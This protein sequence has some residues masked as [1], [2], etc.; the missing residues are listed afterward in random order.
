MILL[1]DPTDHFVEMVNPLTVRETTKAYL[2]GLFLEL[3]KVQ[4]FRQDSIVLAYAGAC[5]T[6]RFEK[7]QELGDW[8][9]WTM[10]FFPK[11]HAGN[12]AIV[13][14]LGR[15]SYD[16]CWR[17]LRGQWDVYAELSELFPVIV[18][19]ISKQIST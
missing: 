5:A 9:L 8:S 13:I 10:A 18:R 16:T 2:V 6:G 12:Q 4:G 11:Y 19:D 15:R 7:F 14:D 1:R 17:L 3:T